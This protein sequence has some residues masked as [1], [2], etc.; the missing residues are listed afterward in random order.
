MMRHP[1]CILSFTLLGLALIEATQ[2][3]DSR[4]NI[5]V[6]YSDDHGHADL[7]VQGVVQDIK[8]PH[9]DAL[10]RRGVV[11]RNGYSTAPQCVP[12]RGGLMVGKF[13]G[14][15]NLDNNGSSLEGFN[16]ETTIARRL[17]DAG[18]ATAH[19]GKW[20]LG[21]TEEIPQHGFM[22]TFSQNAGRP[23]SSNITLDGQDRPMGTLPPE[24]YHIEGCSR[25]AASII[26][27]YKDQPFFLYVAY[28][29]PHT[30]LDAPAKYTR[31]FPGPMPERRRQALAML[32]AVDDGVGLIHET[33]VKNNLSDRTLIFFIG[34]NGAPLKIHKADRPLD[35]D[36]GGWDGSL[37]TPLNGEK[38]MLA[39]GGMHVP[40][41]ISWPG[42]IE[43]GKEFKH[44]V[45]ALDV[46]ATAVSVAN[47]TTKPGEL[48][49]VN[50]IPFLK[51][52]RAEPPHES[53]LW[54]WSAQSAIREGNWKLLRGGER[55][56]LFDLSSDMEEK[57]NRAAEH[58]EIAN[59]L[60]GKLTAWCSELQPP[61]LAVG[62]MAKAWNDYFDYY[63]DGKPAPK[64]PD[65]SQDSPKS[66][67]AAGG[68]QARGGTLSEKDGILEFK[69]AGTKGFIT[70]NGLQLKPP[71]TV[72]LTTKT[73]EKGELTI[74]WRVSGEQ[75]FKPAHQLRVP[76]DTL[77]SWHT[78]SISL[79]GQETIVHLRIHLPKGNVQI[80]EI[81][82]R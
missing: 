32:S 40:F 38:G 80:R 50:L 2:A 11:A 29:A 47:L 9:L 66:Q 72:K 28:R 57:H 52:E 30:P 5:I 51:G 58:P 13:Q 35:G 82:L 6:I 12:S 34:D 55:E 26:D 44:P 20:H 21:P 81:E 62:P 70:R 48:D 54:R 16:K 59:R 18:Y 46:A 77:N 71:T 39:E 49:G 1:L 79:P 78:Q 27:R 22:H 76:V 4:P 14:R 68:W 36:A 74:A 65:D 17:R 15:F 23:F 10:A 75:D 60:R 31:R 33:L 7:G 19:F 3:A 45:S 61:G 42:A 73:S 56:Y 63:L 69:N 43:S 67:T 53:L 8:T 24:M 37:N 25:A 41:L 64:E